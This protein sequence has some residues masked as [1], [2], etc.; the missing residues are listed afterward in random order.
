VD[1]ERTPLDGGPD[2]IGDV[3]RSIEI[4]TNCETT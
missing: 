1:E 3:C 2:V 4:A